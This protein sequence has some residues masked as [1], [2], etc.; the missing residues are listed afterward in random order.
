V[1]QDNVVYEDTGAYLAPDAPPIDLEEWER[2][3]RIEFQ[4]HL[5]AQR[6]ASARAEQLLLSVLCEESRRQLATAGFFTVRAQSGK[7][8]QIHRGR[9]RNVRW[10]DPATGRTLYYCCHPAEH[11]PDADTMLSQK[12]MLELQ[13][14][15]FLRLANV[16]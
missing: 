15:E 9:T 13:E 14:A 8:Y 12:L 10:R 2:G 16:S 5:E 6:V 3:L 7:V 4:G 1:Y 11:V